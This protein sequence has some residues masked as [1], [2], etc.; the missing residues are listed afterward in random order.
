MLSHMLSKGDLIMTLDLLLYVAIISSAICIVSLVGRL[1][2]ST[3]NPNKNATTVTISHW[4][5]NPQ[6]FLPRLLELATQL[7]LLM[8]W[9]SVITMLVVMI[10]ACS[11]ANKVGRY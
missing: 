7:S 3:Q 1:Y 5:L 10:G 6:R 4:Q 11:L 2:H 8:F 9:S